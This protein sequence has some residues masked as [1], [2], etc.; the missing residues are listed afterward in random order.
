MTLVSAKFA[1]V[2]ALRDAIVAPGHM[3]AAYAEKMIHAV[4]NLPTVKDRARYLVE[5]AKDKVVLDIGCTGPISLSIRKSSKKYYGVD[6]VASEGVVAVDIDHR[7]DQIPVYED[8]ETVILS[9]VIEHLANPGYFL[10]ALKKLYAG[11]TFYITVPNA[12]AYAVKDDCEMVNKDHVAWY[13]YT[14]LKT[15]LTRYG[16]EIKEARW[17]GVGGHKSEG[18]IMVVSTG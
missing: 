10:M 9:E 1:S 15:L 11:R 5:K 16:Y 13:S 2:S 7:P 17:Y 14:T 4:P 8:A 12:G 6:R 18:I 3:D